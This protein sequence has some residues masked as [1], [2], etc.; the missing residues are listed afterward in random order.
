MGLLAGLRGQLGSR[1]GSGGRGRAAGVQGQWPGPV[2]CCMGAWP[3]PRSLIGWPGRGG[4]RAQVRPGPPSPEAL[5]QVW[6]LFRVSEAGL[7]GGGG[8]EGEG[9]GG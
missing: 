7:R 3:R 2:Q 8:E 1:A 9:E 5:P 4:A 6:P